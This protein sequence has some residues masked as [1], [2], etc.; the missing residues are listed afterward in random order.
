LL[1]QRYFP[2]RPGE[3]VS[4][5]KKRYNDALHGILDESLGVVI[6]P[7]HTAVTMNADKIRALLPPTR[8]SR[9]P[10]Y[11][12]SSAEIDYICEKLKSCDGYRMAKESFEQTRQ[13]RAA[14]GL[15]IEQ[16][17]QQRDAEGLSI[18]SLDSYIEKTKDEFKR[19]MIEAIDRDRRGTS[20]MYYGTESLSIAADNFMAIVAK[21]Y[22]QEELNI[23]ASSINTALIE[24]AQSFCTHQDMAGCERGFAGRF[25]NAL[26]MIHEHNDNPI[27]QAA[28]N[29]REEIAER[30]YRTVIARGL[31]S[32]MMALH[33]Q[34]LYL[35]LGL[36]SGHPISSVISHDQEK[37]FMTHIAR[38]YTPSAL[39]DQCIA[40]IMD[41]VKSSIRDD[42]DAEIY[43]LFKTLEIIGSHDVVLSQE[44]HHAID[45]IARIDSNDPG[46]KWSL[47]KI[48]SL[49]PAP[50]VA[51]LQS[52]ELCDSRYAQTLQ[53]Q[54][55]DGQS[56]DSYDKHS[57]PPSL[58]SR[59][60]YSQRSAA[61]GANVQ[62]VS[63]SALAEKPS[64]ASCS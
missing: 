3:S 44:E 35:K 19:R 36:S 10:L 63:K 53:L 33:K 54:S 37:S 8:S 43:N 28:L 59:P 32:S 4:D 39:Y 64:T 50:I 42:N 26:A 5:M 48:E 51:K 16:T 49:L 15:S 61:G 31:E 23:D 21:I 1:A 34:N 18:D 40:M 22:Y 46:S 17:R 25:T 20:S 58:F 7:A 38:S 11:P 14:E 2:L 13:Q 6:K 27:H 47:S 60:I 30:A 56:I 24:I 57:S 52:E 12:I 41:N 9:D 62:S 55:K 45:S 29:L